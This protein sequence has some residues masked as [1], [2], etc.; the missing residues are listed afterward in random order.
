MNRLSRIS[1]GTLVDLSARITQDKAVDETLLRQRDRAIGQDLASLRQ[2]PAKQL[3]AWLDQVN[4]A[5]VHEEPAS[6]GEQVRQACGWGLLILGVLGLVLGWTSAQ[7]VF[8]Y[9]GSQPVNVIAVLAAYVLLPI[10][11][12]IP[13]V[14]AMLPLGLSTRRTLGA[15]SPGRLLPIVVRRLPGGSREALESVLG[16]VASQ[17]A[18]FGRVQKWLVL[19]AA[20]V[21]AVMFFFGVVL[22]VLRLIVFSDLAFG[23]STTLRLSTDQVAVG[24]EALAWPWGT[25]WAQAKPSSELV[26]LT[27]YFRAQGGLPQNVAAL[28]GWWP[29]LLA[30]LIFYAFLPRVVLLGIARGRLRWALHHAMLHVPGSDRV[31]DRLNHPWVETRAGVPAQTSPTGDDANPSVIAV[32]T[33]PS[34]TLVNWSHFPV[35]E[36]ALKAR[37]GDELATVFHAGGTASLADDRQVIAQVSAEH[38]QQAVRVLV[39]AW[40]PPTLELADFINDLRQAIGPG[41]PIEVILAQAN[42]EAVDRSQAQQWQHTL[43]KQGD[44]WLEVMAM[45]QQQGGQ[46]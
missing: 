19:G 13:T 31:L 21:F 9:D 33:R 45:P 44:P 25:W 26:A 7:A 43:E 15:I 18:V 24:V 16:Q 3:A 34:R 46:P 35:E 36:T 41:V 32:S 38:A 2:Q 12:L 22:A 14:L 5:S 8:W 27:R 4:Q 40:E 20:Q 10:L 29:F 28:G 39:K 17:G 30:C 11:L 42:L 23:W 37:L 6:P 1:L